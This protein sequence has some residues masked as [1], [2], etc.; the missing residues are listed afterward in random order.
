[1]GNRHG[2]MGV[3]INYDAD[4]QASVETASV[5]KAMDIE[6]DLKDKL[7][8]KIKENEGVEATV[9]VDLDYYDKVD[10]VATFNVNIQFEDEST[11]KFAEFDGD[12][13]QPPDADDLIHEERDLEGIIDKAMATLV[14]LMQTQ[15][16]LLTGQMTW[17]KFL[18]KLMNHT[19][20]QN[21]M[22]SNL[23]LIK[24]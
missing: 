21:M 9:T 15:K 22:K 20:I 7:Q 1:M 6:A 17:T 24:Q 13:Y 18:K 12:Y 16:S 23:T 19:I 3:A 4:L 11:V 8:S 14:I 5:D 2:S 10:E